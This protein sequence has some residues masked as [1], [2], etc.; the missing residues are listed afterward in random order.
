MR[1]EDTKDPE[2]K[3]YALEIPTEAFSRR[4]YKFVDMNIG[5]FETL[6]VGAFKWKTQIIGSVSDEFLM[7]GITSGRGSSYSY[8]G[9]FGLNHDQST[10][11]AWK[12]YSAGG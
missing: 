12:A 1:A 4:D 8:Q 10:T 2:N 3:S 5:I 11:G 9:M 6:L 7:F